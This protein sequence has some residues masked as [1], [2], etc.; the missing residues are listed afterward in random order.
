MPLYYGYS[1]FY[2]PIFS[3]FY[4]LKYF[5]TILYHIESTLSMCFCAFCTQSTLYFWYFFYS[6]LCILCLTF[7]SQC[8]II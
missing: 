6:I 5:V 4:P 3:I 2:L 1:K 7:L 8:V